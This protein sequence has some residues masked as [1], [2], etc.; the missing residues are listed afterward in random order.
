MDGFSPAFSGMF[1]GIV[2]FSREFPIIYNAL[3]V[4]A[5]C[6][7]LI[8]CGA[9]LWIFIR[10][11]S[12]PAMATQSPMSI[13]GLLVCLLAGSLLLQVGS[14][15]GVMTES[16]F[17]TTDLVSISSYVDK[18]QSATTPFEA[19]LF[20]VVAGFVLVGWIAGIRA[21]ILLWRAGN[22]GRGAN[23]N[24]LY[25]QVLWHVIGGIFLINIQHVVLDAGESFGIHESK[26]SF[27]NF[28]QD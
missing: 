9:S 13:G 17:E 28:S 12:Q 1:S 2:S 24:S 4:F 14:F 15:M 11:K 27:E 25:S 5:G 3:I 18:A 10:N 7:G 6:M 21:L 20:A 8:L 23:G 22:G 26:L 19:G 16:F